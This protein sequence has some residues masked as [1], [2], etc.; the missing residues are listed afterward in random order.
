MEKFSRE[1][2]SVTGWIDKGD[3]DKIDFL[4]PV[5]EIPKIYKRPEELE[6]K[7]FWAFEVEVTVKLLR[8]CFVIPE[9]VRNG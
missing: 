7:G 1:P 9:K 4:A 3:Y 5:V 2:R 8:T 6:V